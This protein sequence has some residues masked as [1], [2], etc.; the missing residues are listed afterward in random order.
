MKKLAVLLSPLPFALHAAGAFAASPP[1][2]SAPPPPGIGDILQQAAP[3]PRAPE[4][5]P[6]P[7]IQGVPAEPPLTKLPGNQATIEVHDFT[8]V[9]NRVV[10]ADKLR[11]LVDDAKGKKLSLADLQD[12]AT[13]ITRY[14]RGHGY[15]VARAYIPAQE[16]VGQT[17]TIRVIEGQYGDFHLQN[18]A[19][20][21][22]GIAQDILDAVRD[23]DIVSVDTLERAMMILNDTPGTRVTQVS[24]SPGTKIGTSDF[25][26][27]TEPTPL[28]SGQVAL[29]DYGGLYTGRGRVSVNASIDGPTH[30]GDRVDV[31]ALLDENNELNS[32]RLAYTTLLTPTG[33]TGEL[34]VSRTTYKL[35]STY[36]D[37]DAYGHATSIDGQLSYP[38]VL[39]ETRRLQAVFGVQ[40]SDLLD[41]ISSTDT[42]TPK[43]SDTISPG[44]E[45]STTSATSANS[46]GISVTLGELGI[47][48]PSAKELD[49]EGG[50]TDGQFAKIDAH[51][52]HKQSL[53][54]GLVLDLDARAQVVPGGKSLDG[55]QKLLVSG[56]TAVQAY[57]PDELLGDDGAIGRVTLSRPFTIR[58]VVVLTP[59]AFFDVGWAHNGYTTTD[60]PS[61][62]TLTDVGPGLTATYRNI[63]ASVEWAHRTSGGKAIAE[64]TPTDRILARLAVLF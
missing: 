64:P 7:P 34:G 44:L 41:E 49:A 30:S 55:S 40:H 62:R 6:L 29:D 53:P 32:G 52:D 51:A 25:N 39:T 17:V 54:R 2:P 9:G 16:V 12:L 23:K 58:E 11:A 59:S 13:R 60:V 27:T 45:F 38:I 46:A 14:Y 3:P 8:I 37:L 43:Q 26:V 18:H 22:D 63:V 4:E 15:F 31:F 36:K 24:V 10:D 48:S 61:D 47:D 33:L 20:L 1:P 28:V 21:R 57:S 5:T 19:R 35:G 42:K 50:K 56:D